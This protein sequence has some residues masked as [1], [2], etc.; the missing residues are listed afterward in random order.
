MSELHQAIG[1]MLE[2][3]DLS[4]ADKTYEALRE[5]LQEMVLLGLYCIG[6]RYPTPFGIAVIGKRRRVLVLREILQKH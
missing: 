2:K 6:G 4:T 5:I 1:K 3:Y